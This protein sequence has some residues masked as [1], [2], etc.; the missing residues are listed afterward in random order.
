MMDSIDQEWTELQAETRH[1]AEN[2]VDPCQ[3]A[4]LADFE[5]AEKHYLTALVIALVEFAIIVVLSVKLAKA[6][7]WIS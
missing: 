6:W 5:W 1:R 2:I 7:G 4:L 3:D